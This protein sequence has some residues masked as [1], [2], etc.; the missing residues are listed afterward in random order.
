MSRRTIDEHVVRMG[1]DNTNFEKNVAQSLG[2]IEKLSA[3]ISTKLDTTNFNL[4]TA[5]ANATGKGFSALANVGIGALRN[6]GSQIENWSINTIKTLTGVNNVITGF[7]KFDEINKATGTLVSQGFAMQEI[8]TELEQLNWFSDETS[9]SLTDMTTNIAKFTATGMGLKD[10]SEAIRGIALWAALSGQNAVTAS[11]AMYQLSQALG[12]GYMRLEDWKSIQNVSMD[13]DEFRQHALDAAVA[14]GTLEKSTDGMYR[15][16]VATSKSGGDW[17]SKS[18]FATSLTEGAW[19]T[20]DVMMSVYQEYSSAVD[21]I[22]E[23]AEEHGVTASMAIKALEDELD[24][25]AVKAFRA[26]Q[27][28]RT[29]ADAIGSVQDASSS[30]WAAIFKNIFGNYEEATSLFTDLANTMYDLF[31]EPINNIVQLFADWHEQGGRNGFVEGLMN[32]LYALVNVVGHVQDAFSEIFPQVTVNQLLVFSKKFANWSRE[33]RSATVNMEGFRGVVRGIVSI[34][35]LLWQAASGLIRAVMPIVKSLGEIFGVI[36][37]IIGAVFGLG[38]GIS[39]AAKESDAF[40]KIFSTI[41]W[42]VKVVLE[43][44]ATGMKAVSKWFK[45]VGGELISSK[46]TALWEQ[47]KKTF[48]ELGN[49]AYDLFV[50]LTGKTPEQVFENIQKKAEGALESVKQFFG[51]SDWDS[52]SKNVLDKYNRSV[53]RLGTFI[54]DFFSKGNFLVSYFEGGEGVSGILEVIFDKVADLVR[55]LFDLFGIWTDLDVDETKENVVKWIQKAR[56]V[57]V[58]FADAIE[59]AFGKAIEWFKNLG[60]ESENTE[61]KLDWS[62]VSAFFMSLWELVQKV[63]TWITNVAAKVWAAIE[64]YIIKAK[65][66]IA[67]ADFQTFIDMLKG[68]GTALGG[69]GIFML[70][71]KLKDMISGPD[72]LSSKFG[73]FVDSLTGP[74]NALKNV[75]NGFAMDLAAEDIKKVATAIAILAGAMFV[76]SLIDAHALGLVAGVLMYLIAEITGAIILIKKFTADDSGPST[77][78]DQISDSIDSLTST[79]NRNKTISTIGTTL[80]K[81]ALAILVLAAALKIISDIP[82]EDLKRSMGAMI[83]F[84]VALATFV[85]MLT[86]VSESNEFD[87]KRIKAINGV[88]VKLGVSIMILAAALLIISKIPAHELKRSMIAITVLLVALMGAIALLGISSEDANASAIKAIGKALIEISLAIIIIA[89]AMQMI[90]KLKPNEL[91][92]SMLALIAIMGMLTLMIMAFQVGKKDLDAGSAL[93]I[94]AIAATIIVLTNALERLKDIDIMSLIAAGLTLT[95]V[96]G[97]IAIAVGYMADK[98]ADMLKIGAGLLMLGVSLAIVAKVVEAFS[99]MEI[100]GI[101]LGIAALVAILAAFAAAAILI[102][103]FN[104]VDALYALSLTFLSFGAG[105]ALTGLGL[106]LVGKGLVFLAAGI[107]AIVG[108]IALFVAGFI[109]GFGLLLDG[110]LTL[111]PKIASFGVKLVV[112]FIQG[113]IQS[114]PQISQAGYDMI[115]ALLNALLEEDRLKNLVDTGLQVL[116]AFLEGISN[117]I[118]QITDTCIKIVLGF[119]EGIEKNLPDIVDEA[120]EL[121]I[122]FVNSLSDAIDEHAEDLMEAADKLIT[123]LIRALVLCLTLGHTDLYEEVENLQE[124]GIFTALKNWV[125]DSWQKIKDK[126]KEIVDHLIEGIKSK[127][128][129]VKDAVKHLADGFVEGIRQFFTPTYAKMQGVADKQLSAFESV[130]EINSPSKKM[131]WEV[132]MISQ[133]LVRG[134]ETYGGAAVQA[135]ATVG[136]NMLKGFEGAIQGVYDLVDGSMDYDPVIRPILDLTDLE[137]GMTKAN[138]M[139]RNRPMFSGVLSRNLSAID[140]MQKTDQTTNSAANSGTINYTQYNYSPKALNAIEIYRRTRNQLSAMKGRV[141]AR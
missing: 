119:I 66:A 8:E 51:I 53:E 115:M 38:E 68:A 65:D 26:G 86:Q 83:V 77:I 30:A 139:F 34:L 91:K 130:Y 110:L 82:A 84:L 48:E 63:G 93:A 54:Q 103:K 42:P 14:V 81:V 15:S 131:K 13:T 89:V 39:N 12:A 18:Q 60:S 11:R 32:L 73:K 1:F 40:F 108:V 57:V 74:F 133:G 128:Q 75:L 105:L 136:E 24:P 97:A 69:F 37:E 114:I 64:P 116:N 46:L 33:V 113:I 29:W 71:K 98:D 19:F 20:K 2:T 52:F 132:K 35:S 17:F 134:F 85:F 141:G 31:V 67:N 88:L 25:F 137:N 78:M 27:E 124:V 135:S 3:A 126:A 10:S 104:A 101:V 59:K 6:L 106:V 107:T 44:I 117:N 43:A 140:G 45:E 122:T 72:S 16:L 102:E 92:R 7:G 79:F 109:K 55:L 96:M 100:G 118:E 58:D 49:S 41:L 90:A 70:F 80:I 94:L 95:L 111:I 28:A 21:K 112:A 9:Y 129:D 120:F 56:N 87:A 76:L 121:I 23:Y 138:G 36:M 4:A 99:K 61:K 5:A 50:K 123:S 62:S 125:R 22:Y 47:T 127:W